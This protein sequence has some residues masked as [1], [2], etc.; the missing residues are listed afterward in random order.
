M[1]KNLIRK[2]H[3]YQK[4][5]RGGKFPQPHPKDVELMLD[6]CI[7]LLRRL[8]DEQYNELMDG[9]NSREH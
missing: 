9:S 2:L 4:W 1:R 3:M 5:R 8:S 7:R 6:D